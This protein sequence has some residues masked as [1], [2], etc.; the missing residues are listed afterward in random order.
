M[1]VEHAL[2]NLQIAALQVDTIYLD[3]DY[4]YLRTYRRFCL[5]GIGIPL[6]S[7]LGNMGIRDAFTWPK[8]V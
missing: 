6:H 8:K 3:R 1:E 2:A 7:P 5:H 4:I